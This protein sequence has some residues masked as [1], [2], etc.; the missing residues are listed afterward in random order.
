MSKILRVVTP[1]FILKEGDTLE[2]SKDGNHY[3]YALHEEFRNVS[4]SESEVSSELK[5]EFSISTA[6]AQT[7]IDDGYLEEV[8]EDKKEFVNIF[9]EIDKLLTKYTAEQK[10][11]NADMDGYPECVK[12]ER[13]TVLTNLITLLT[14][15]KGLKK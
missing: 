5:A 14:H 4:V 12:L 3:E 15:L 1:F 9:D 11:L 8:A 13:N 6:Y 7:L 10:S 2:L